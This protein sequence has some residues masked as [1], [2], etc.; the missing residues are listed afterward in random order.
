[1]SQQSIK[2]MPTLHYEIPIGTRVTVGQ[3]YCSERN[4]TIVGISSCHVIFTYIV[5]LDE[6]VDS[7]YGQMRAIAV[8]GPELSSED[9]K[10]NW[11]LNDTRNSQPQA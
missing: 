11:R 10:T 1:M 7:V 8:N 4:G 5:L 6:P 9:G 2:Y 3:P